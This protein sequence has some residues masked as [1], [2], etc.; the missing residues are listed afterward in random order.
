MHVGHQTGIVSWGAYV[1]PSRIPVSAIMSAR[2]RRGH[3]RPSRVTRPPSFLPF[4]L[5]IPS[6]SE[7][8]TS[9]AVAACNRAL[10][11]TSAVGCQRVGALFLG[12]ESRGGYKVRPTSAVVAGL[13]GANRGMR[14][15]DIEA[16]CAGGI[17]ALEDAL[18][19][20]QVGKVSYAL[21]V[22]SDVALYPPGGAELTQGAGAAAIL[23]GS[24]PEVIARPLGSVALAAHVDDFFRR[25]GQEYPRYNA[26]SSKQ[27]YVEL[28][29]GAVAGLLD[30]LGL[31]LRDFSMAVFH[32]PY[33]GLT[34]DLAR[35]GLSMSSADIAR[36]V[37]P[38]LVGR[39]TG[40]TYTASC[41]LSLISA[42]ENA[43]P[44]EKIL[45]CSYGSGAVACALGFEVVAP[46]T[47]RR[48]QLQR[49]LDG[50][51]LISFGAYELWRQRYTQLRSQGGTPFE[52]LCR[53]DECTPDRVS[54]SLCRRCGRVQGV[55]RTPT[56]AYDDCGGT[57]AS[58]SFPRHGVITDVTPVSGPVR[59]ALAEGWIP[60]EMNGLD[61]GCGGRHVTLTTRVTEIEGC[62][63]AVLYGPAYVDTTDR[64]QA[65]GG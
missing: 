61:N 18:D 59:L 38:Y 58:V 43:R 12:S 65:A 11:A 33:P 41:L 23:V 46:V 35:N 29:S 26:R 14:V 9:M 48:P 6:S 56:C 49:M 44:G 13:I 32:V 60:L 7:D 10:T 30:K 1:P 39:H 25:D 40:N 3:A 57:V 51:E 8:S 15:K 17:V 5:A 31:S 20:V 63:G 62:D 27:A 24:G 4:Q 50:G 19:Q 54:V 21:A 42:L 64:S 28:C 55:M 52:W 2:R 47:S 36:M 34:L 16:A 53:V 45:V 37:E 22:G